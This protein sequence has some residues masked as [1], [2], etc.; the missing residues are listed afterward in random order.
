MAVLMFDP[1]LNIQGASISTVACYAVAGIL[2]LVY[3]IRLTG[4]RVSIWD[5]FGKPIVASL[6]MGGTV[7]FAGAFLKNH[8]GSTAATLGSVAVGVVIYGALVIALRMFSTEEL[9]FIPGGARL[10]GLL[11]R[12]GE[13]A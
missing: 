7:Y 1:A 2:D 12:K 3:L 6:A 11:G 4:M 5:C 9:A 8:V 10:R 13:R